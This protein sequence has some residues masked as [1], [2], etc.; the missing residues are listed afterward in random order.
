MWQ[1]DHK[2]GRILKNWCFWTVV[3]EKTL[4]SLLNS[5]GI[6]PVTPQ[7]IQSLIFIGRTDAEA[8]A[9]ILWPP[10]AKSWLIG[11]DPD[12]GKDWRWKEK[13]APE[14]ETV[15]WHHWLNGHEFERTLGDGGGQRSL[16]GYSPGASLVLIDFWMGAGHQRGQAMIKSWNVQ[17]YSHS[18]DK[19]EG[20]EMKM[21]IVHIYESTCQCRRHKWHRFDLWV[22]KIPWRR[23][24]QP[25]PVFLPAELHGQGSLK[26]YSP[27]GC[28]VGHDWVHTHTHTHTH[29]HNVM[30]RPRNPNSVGLGGFPG[31]LNTST[32]WESE[33][34]QLY[35]DRSSCAQNPSRPWPTHLFIWLFIC[36]LYHIL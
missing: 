29:T 7:G 10:D 30:K 19:R 21:V 35:G 16:A 22:R 34:C 20:L 25:A 28:R 27:W 9:P 33:A 17:P 15:G 3:L 8:K 4:E 32:Y 26:G 5:K 2:E 1:L 23:K 6:K 11:K 31:G 13:G 24:W 14:D 12:A 36:I 18:L